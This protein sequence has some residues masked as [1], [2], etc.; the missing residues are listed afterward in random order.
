MKQDRLIYKK[1]IKELPKDM[2]PMEKALKEGFSPLSNEELL[3]IS[4]G[5]GIKGINAIGLAQKILNRKSFKDL[6]DIPLGDWKKIKGIGE[7]KA[8][9]I[10]AIIE[11][12]KRMD[13]HAKIKISFVSDAFNYLKFLSKETKRAYGSFILKQF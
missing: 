1:R 2:L 11:I 8:L 10:L 9:Q 3:A 4:I 7:A 5:S 6:K 13:D 12:A